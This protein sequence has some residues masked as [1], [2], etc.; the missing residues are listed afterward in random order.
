[1]VCMILFISINN[2]ILATSP[3]TIEYIWI[4]T[5]IVLY[6]FINFEGKC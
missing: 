2:C 3:F 4:L 1:M 5:L 6:N